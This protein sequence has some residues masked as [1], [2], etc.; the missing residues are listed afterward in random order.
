VDGGTYNLSITNPHFARRKLTNGDGF[1]SN[2]KKPRE[3]QK[4]VS[5]NTGAIP[6][7]CN[8]F[9]MRKQEPNQK[10]STGAAADGARMS[11]NL[12]REEPSAATRG[13]FTR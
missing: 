9:I 5:R 13:L 10:K 2:Q 7:C 8:E 3:T 4:M 12:L 6:L 11:L 1:L